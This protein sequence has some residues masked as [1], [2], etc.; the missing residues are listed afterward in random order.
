MSNYLLRHLQTLLASAGQMARAPVA[1][2]LTLVVI[3][4]TLALPA[5]LYVALTNIERVSAGWDR[6]AQISL[7]LKRDTSDA[8]ALRLASQIRSMHAVTSVD[9]ITRDA[10]LDEFRRLS[11]F[12]PAL[13]VLGSNPLP[14]VLVVRPGRDESPAAVEAL[15]TDLAGLPG[16]DLAELDVAWLKRLAAILSLAQRTVWILAVLL[17]TAV[18]LIIGNTIRLAVLNRVTEIEV[19]QLVGGT[20]AFVRRPFLYYGLFHGLAGGVF[21]WLLVEGTLLLLSGPAR[22]LAGLYGS[23]FA[24]NGLGAGSSLLLTAGGGLLGWLGSRLAVDWQLRRLK[25]RQP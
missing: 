7:F 21:A 20:P 24:L 13:N 19:I 2:L 18:L 11:G 8:V 5:G 6:G 22:E 23:S 9:Y 15:R 3:G 1:T 17:A 25:S 16:V 14:A 10:A 12:G 4:I